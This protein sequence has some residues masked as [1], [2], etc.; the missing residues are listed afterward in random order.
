MPLMFTLREAKASRNPGFSIFPLLV[1]LL[2][3]LSIS[4]GDSAKYLNLCSCHV[5]M[6]SSLCSDSSSRLPQLQDC[7]IFGLFYYT[8]RFIYVY[9]ILKVKRFVT[10]HKK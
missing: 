3:V 4:L 8:R 2:K 6:V 7:P 9:V 10:I 5:I 1:N